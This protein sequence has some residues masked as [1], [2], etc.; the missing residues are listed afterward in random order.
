MLPEFAGC[1]QRSTH[2]KC[3]TFT[4]KSTSRTIPGSDH[5]I[6]H[7]EFGSQ[8]AQVLQKIRVISN[9]LKANGNYMYHTNW[10]SNFLHFFPTLSAHVLRQI[11]KTSAS[12]FTPL[13]AL[14]GCNRRGR[15][16]LWSTNW[17]FIY[18][19]DVTQWG[20]PSVSIQPLWDL[21][22]TNSH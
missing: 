15:C 3:K 20:P 7:N 8:Y 21:L 19:L 6:L 18:N 9:Y 5:R 12:S 22:W 1:G 17:I 10:H 14:A 2:C 13:T 11:V 16:S 4:K